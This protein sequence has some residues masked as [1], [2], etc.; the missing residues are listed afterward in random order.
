M[1]VTYDTGAL[2]AGD[3]GE[4]RLWAL[5]AG[6]LAEGIV[7]TVPAAVLAQAWRGG[8]PQANLARLL[9]PCA[10]D[11]LTAVDARR[12]G[13]LLAASGT[14]D[15]VD[16]SVVEGALR[17]GDAVVSTDPDDLRHLATAAGRS[18]V[19]ERP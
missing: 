8:P 11:E 4:R 12:A 9:A 3:R 16:A 1:G 15:V 7:P 18:L 2:I 6:L 14:D 17:R 5:H 13:A 10:I 19:V